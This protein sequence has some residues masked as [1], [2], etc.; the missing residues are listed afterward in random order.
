MTT[1]EKCAR[2]N[3]QGRVVIEPPEALD[4][5]MWHRR[6]TCR[7]CG[8]RFET[9]RPGLLVAIT[10]RDEPIDWQGPNPFLNEPGT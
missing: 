5:N 1:C 10:S 9:L 8:W 3:W 6:I 2:S 7:W 4:R